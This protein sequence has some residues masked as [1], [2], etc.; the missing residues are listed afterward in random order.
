MEYS[1]ILV[2]PISL[3]WLLP[4]FPVHTSCLGMRP[5]IMSLFRYVNI[6]WLTPLPGAA[7]TQPR[8]PARPG[9]K[10]KGLRQRLTRLRGRGSSRR[11]ATAH[12]RE[13]LDW[14]GMCRHVRR[15]SRGEQ[16]MCRARLATGVERRGRER[17]RD[18]CGGV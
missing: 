15:M 8:G 9:A 18:F 7:P 6:K 3:D 17:R 1:A 10:R 2:L 13:R 11:A 16:M 14:R 12:P 4:M 5:T